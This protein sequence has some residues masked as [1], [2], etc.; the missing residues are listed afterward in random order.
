[1]HEIEWVEPEGEPAGGDDTLDVGREWSATAWLARVMRWPS[2]PPGFGRVAL[3]PVALVAALTFGPSGPGPV[4]ASGRT[5]PH[6]PMTWTCTLSQPAAADA[7]PAARNLPGSLLAEQ[8]QRRPNGTA[9]V[10]ETRRRP[11]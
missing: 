10:S 3:A 8:V 9:C 7:A 4:S 6:G 2:R 1:V 11:P 5:V